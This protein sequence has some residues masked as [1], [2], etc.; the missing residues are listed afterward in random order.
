MEGLGPN[1]NKSIGEKIKDLLQNKQ[2]KEALI[3][4]CFVLLATGFWFMQSLQQEYEIHARIPIQYENF[5]PDIA[6]K[7]TL[8]EAYE[9]KI[10]D[11]GA[12]LLN[13]ELGS[14]FR[15]SV[16]N[17]EK[18]SNG[19][20]AIKI[21]RNDIDKEIKKQLISSTSLISFEPQ[22]LN[23]TYEKKQE[24]EVP[25]VFNGEISTKAGYKVVGKVKC[26][27]SN[28]RIFASRA[29]LD[30]IKEVKTDFLSFKDAGK[31]IKKNVQIEKIRGV[32]FSNSSVTII[33]DIEQYTEKTLEVPVECEDLPAGY[34]LRTFPSVVKV[35]CG[36][37]LSI[38]K[39]I[40]AK[41]FSINIPFADVEQNIVSGKITL[42][43]DKYPA[44]VD[45]V[46]I[47]PDKIEFILEHKAK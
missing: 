44:S 19:K 40:S 37:P 20:N 42:K 1:K 23:I 24:K 34:T 13:Y 7:D 43:I 10:K 11:R 29:K 8:P 18:I 16:V 39:D 30:S 36:V 21:N 26:N 3:F 5:P 33:A 27:P 2:L 4:L 47:E 38:F 9:I 45:N 31:T 41:D 14:G 12:V 35:S 15:P 6:F 32:S 46:S 28:I 25:V 17:F 22:S